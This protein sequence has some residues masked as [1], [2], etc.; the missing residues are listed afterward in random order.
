[1][2]SRTL[3]RLYNNEEKE[4]LELKLIE[5]LELKRIS[6][7]DEDNSNYLENTQCFSLKSTNKRSVSR[8]IR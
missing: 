4:K 3:A 7:P 2:Y 8:G 5:L 1:M 6:T